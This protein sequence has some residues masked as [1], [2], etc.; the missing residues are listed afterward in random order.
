MLD[1]RVGK[2]YAVCNLCH[3]MRDWALEISGGKKW[4]KYEFPYLKI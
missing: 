3:G 2:I 4:S 1:F